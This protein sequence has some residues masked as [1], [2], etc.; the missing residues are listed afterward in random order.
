MWLP[1]Q[2]YDYLMHHGIM[3]MQWGKQNG[4]PYPLD[5]EDHS[6][7]EKKDGWKKSLKKNRNASLREYHEIKKKAKN[8]EHKKDIKEFSKMSKEEFDKEYNRRNELATKLVQESLTKSKTKGENIAKQETAQKAV[9]DFLK[10]YAYKKELE[11][12]RNGGKS[13]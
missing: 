1:T 2:R 5:A 9:N 11:R 3:G 7:K 12:L 13:K 10:M 8:K 6:A 4:P